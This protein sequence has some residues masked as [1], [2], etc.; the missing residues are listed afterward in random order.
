MSL[1]SS[2]VLLVVSH[3]RVELVL[4]DPSLAVIVKE[5]TR[6]VSFLDDLLGIS[7]LIRVRSP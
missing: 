3:D 4:R 7:E 2:S 5:G 6:F 1:Q